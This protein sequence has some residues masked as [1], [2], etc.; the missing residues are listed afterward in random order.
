MS[1]HLT[2]LNEALAERYRIK[3]ELGQGGMATVYLADDVRHGRSVALKVLRPEIAAAV[4]RERFL[5]EIKTT[6]GLQHPHILPLH[7]SGDVDG[8]LFYVMPYVEGESLRDRLD[9][10]GQLPVDDAVRLSVTLAQALDYAHRRGI[11]HRDIK[12]ANVL[13]HDGEPVVSDFGIALAVSGG[14]GQRLTETGLSLGTPRYMS[15][16]QAAGDEQVGPATDIWAVGC[17]LYEMLAGEPP[18]TGSTAQSVLAK[19]ITAEPQPVTARRKSVPAYVE[20]VIRRALEKVPADRFARAGELAQALLAGGGGGAPQQRVPE[21]V[22]IAVLPFEDLSPEGDQRYFAEGLSEEIINALAQLPGMKV[23]ARTSTFLLSE[24]GADITAVSAK[25]GVANVLEGSVR[26]SG[27]RIRITAQLIEAASGFHLW[28]RRFDSRVGDVF[29]IQD[30]IARAIAGQFRLT[31]DGRERVRL[32]EGATQNREA[33]EAYLRGRYFWN[34]RASARAHAA[35]RIREGITE[36]Q[37]AI[38]LDPRYAEAYSGLADSYFVLEVYAAPPAGRFVSYTA[39]GVEAA[40]ASV[41][42]APESGICRASLGYGLWLLGDWDGAER[43]FRGAISSSPGYAAARQ[44]YAMY[45]YSTG[46]AQEAL[47]QAQEALELDP[48]AGIH[49]LQLAR[50]YWLMGQT[51]VAI[52][53]LHQATRLA[54]TAAFGWS[55]LGRWLFEL[56]RYEEGLEAWLRW[57]RL[58]GGDESAYT[59][60]YWAAVRYDESGEPQAL[61]EFEMPVWESLWLL[62]HTG[63]ADRVIE[64]LRKEWFD[65]GRYGLLALTHVVFASALPGDD[66]AYRALVEQAGITW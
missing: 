30:E 51:D 47:L 44:W 6:A 25:L 31:L 60:A 37:R 29:E 16:E 12:P 15:P 34:Q 58:V 56:G 2:R 64:L 22:G 11:V 55:D 57:A 40:R 45:L 62:G 66:P 23:A 19:I 10:E 18:F 28:S 61:P 65:A 21:A 52:E 7:D 33:H 26:K 35:E 20:S 48:V 42:F 14:S 38:A 32:V 3:R 4:G 43:E 36:F 17:V 63:Q 59:Q 49:L 54:P 27:D 8:L 1:Q 50:V 13:L 5:A 53:R 24:Q 9:R 46:R 39:E 41:S